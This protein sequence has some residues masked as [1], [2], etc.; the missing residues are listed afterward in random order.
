MVCPVED[1]SRVP[2]EGAAA[3]DE[4]VCPARMVTLR[5]QRV[6]RGALVGREEGG[7]EAQLARW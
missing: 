1:V 7:A 2:A 6:E 3:E 5:E 4:A